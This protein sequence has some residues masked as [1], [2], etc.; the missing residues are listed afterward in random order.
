MKQSPCLLSLCIMSS[1]VICVGSS[2][3]GTTGCVASVQEDAGLF[4]GLAQW[5][6]RVSI[7]EVVA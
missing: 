1:R 3:C 5:V 4:P 7:A 6:N 2:L